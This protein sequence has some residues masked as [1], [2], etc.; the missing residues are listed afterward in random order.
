MGKRDN[1]Y[2]LKGEIELDDAFF[3]TEIPVESKNEPLKRGRGSQKKTKV[4]VIAESRTVDNPKQGNKPKKVGYLKM[5]VVDDLK[6]STITDNVKEQVE[7]TAD[8]I[9]DDSTSYTKLKKYVHSHNASVIPKEQISKVLPWVH[10]AIS[11]AKRQLLGV[12][13]K[14]STH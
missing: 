14:V 11:N 4:L 6:S 1:K 10:T 8:L 7:N 5:I 12:Y 3:T 9:S 13:Y 2:S